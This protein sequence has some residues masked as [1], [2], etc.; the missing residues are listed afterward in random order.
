MT[1]ETMPTDLRH[2]Q[3]L[4][5]RLVEAAMR[6]H[7]PRSAEAATML[8]DVRDYLTYLALDGLGDSALAADLVPA[9]SDLQVGLGRV[10]PGLSP[11]S[12][13]PETVQFYIG[14]LFSLEQLLSLKWCIARLP[15]EE[16]SREAFKASWRRTA[17]RLQEVR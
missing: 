16:I 17:E 8:A 6:L 5:R 3:A 7:R 11:A 10:V 9:L 14:F 1:P 4:L 12:P 13:K 15:G 2:D